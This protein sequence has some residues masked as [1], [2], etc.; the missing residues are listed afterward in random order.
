MR[1]GEQRASDGT[2]DVSSS[3]PG[4]A[5]ITRRSDVDGG[6]R[7]VLSVSVTAAFLHRPFVVGC[8]LAAFAIIFTALVLFETPGLGIAHFFYLP[9]AALALTGGV[10]RGISAGLL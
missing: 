9:V 7:D 5:R 10:Q 8:A 1:W 3:P 4:S 6:R 2:D